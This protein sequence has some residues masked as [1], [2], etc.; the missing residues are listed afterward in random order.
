M[1]VGGAADPAALGALPPNVH[2]EPWIAQETVIPN[3]DAVVC[4]GGYGS[5][6]GALAHGVPLVA[7]PLFGDDQWANARRVAEIGAG[8]ALE[9]DRRPGRRMLDGPDPETLAALPGAI[10]R[11]LADPGYRRAAGGVADAIDALAPVDAAVDA[12]LVA[13]RHDRLPGAARRSARLGGRR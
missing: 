9:G 12:L 1:T 2:V 4:H 10:E 8:V 13:S 5:V 7:L 3:S 6:L 11:V